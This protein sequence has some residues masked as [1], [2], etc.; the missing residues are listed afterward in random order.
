MVVCMV[1]FIC[2]MSRFFKGQVNFLNNFKLLFKEDQIL[3]N[4]DA[5]GFDLN[6]VEMNLLLIVPR[7]NFLFIYLSLIFNLNKEENNLFYK[8]NKCSVKFKIASC[9]HQ[10]KPTWIIISGMQYYCR[11]F[12]YEK[13][14]DGWIFVF[15][16]SNQ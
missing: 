16:R 12:F 14:L 10:N 6:S 7:Y 5:D 1:T 11:H 2:F 9:W 15:L 13:H 4:L 8:Y 3:V